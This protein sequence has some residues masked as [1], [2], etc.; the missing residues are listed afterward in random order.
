MFKKGGMTLSRILVLAAV[1]CF[2]LAAIGVDVQF[3]LVSIGLALGFGSF[4]VP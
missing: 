3:D 4:L 1:V 2:V